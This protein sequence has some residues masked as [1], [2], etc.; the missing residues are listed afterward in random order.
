M[1]KSEVLGREQGLLLVDYWRC[2]PFELDAMVLGGK[3][4]M[5][6]FFNPTVSYLINRYNHLFGKDLLEKIHSM[7]IGLSP[8]DRELLNKTVCRIVKARLQKVISD[9]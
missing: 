2:Q 7:F 5:G 4:I 6:A 3:T 9:N 1:F 8:I